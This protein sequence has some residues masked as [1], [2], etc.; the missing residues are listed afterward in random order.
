[1]TLVLN[2][3]I[4]T[5]RS[6]SYLLV[7]LSFMIATNLSHLWLSYSYPQV[8]L[9]IGFSTIVAISWLCATILASHLHNMNSPQIHTD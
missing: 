6:L 2:S 9:M 1:V 8:F 7:L 3:W 5:R 4:S